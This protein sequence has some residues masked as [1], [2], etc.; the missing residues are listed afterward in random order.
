MN[1]DEND[2]NIIAETDAYFVWRSEEEGEFVYHLELGGVTLHMTSEEWDE[3]VELMK[4]V[5]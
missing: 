4:N 1:H 5:P 2:E 3:L